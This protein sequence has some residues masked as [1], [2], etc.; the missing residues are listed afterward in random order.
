M[1]IEPQGWGGGGKFWEGRESQ[2]KEAKG[3]GRGCKEGG[4]VGSV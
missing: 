3:G 1:G 4:G 2:E